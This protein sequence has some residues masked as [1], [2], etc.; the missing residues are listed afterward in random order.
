MP[1]AAA[2]VYLDLCRDALFEPFDMAD[3][4]DHFAAGVQRV[5]GV[6]GDVQRI[7]VE[8]AEAFIEEE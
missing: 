6:E 1:D 8:C 7:A 5:E 4:A 3:D 2:F